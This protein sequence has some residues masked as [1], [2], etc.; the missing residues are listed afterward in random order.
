LV[1]QDQ[2]SGISP[3]DLPHLFEPFYRSSEALRQNR[4]GVGL[5]LAIVQRIAKTL[6][7]TMEVDSKLRQGASFVLSFPEAA[8]AKRALGTDALT[9]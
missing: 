9:R 4:R 1:V 5:G 7:A 2:G 3:E 8:A 6:G